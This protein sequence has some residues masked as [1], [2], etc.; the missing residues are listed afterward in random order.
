MKKVLFSVFAVAAAMTAC[1]KSDVVDAPNI[2]TPI[3]FAAYSG[4]APISKATSIE[5]QEDL[6]QFVVYAY[7][8]EN[9]VADYTKNYFN[10]TL[11][12]S[13]SE[14][15]GSWAFVAHQDGKVPVYYW[16]SDG[17]NLAFVAY[18]NNGAVFNAP[19]ETTTPSLTVTVD[20][21]VVNQKDVMVATPVSTR[22]ESSSV[23]LAFNHVLSR[24]HFALTGDDRPIVVTSVKV[25]GAFYDE[26]TVDLSTNP[27]VTPTANTARGEYEY[28]SDNYNFTFTPSDNA[29]TASIKYSENAA[30][31]DHYMMIIPSVPTDVVVKF[32]F[33]DDETNSTYTASLVLNE[34]GS[35]SFKFNAGKSYK[36][37]LTLTS[38]KVT[39]GAVVNPWNGTGDDD[40]IL[41]DTEAGSTNDYKFSVVKD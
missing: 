14:N 40:T 7:N 29:T 13:G 36:F 25:K 3:S 38:N 1:S 35:D 23:E 10:E 4:K 41:P 37:H 33:A 24:V 8:T 19:S 21:E 39:F 31:E 22:N 30:A 32:Y 18:S 2:D 11:Q 26:G 17:E 34:N 5:N 20:D 27:V 12:F 28:L 9:G 6:N 16:P 15:T